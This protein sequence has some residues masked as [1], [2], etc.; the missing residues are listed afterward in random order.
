M[1]RPQIPDTQVGLHI[2]AFIRRGLV[3]FL[4]TGNEHQAEND[5]QEKNYFF[6]NAD[7]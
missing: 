4:I 3:K 2:P 6:H 5:R 1:H 7:L